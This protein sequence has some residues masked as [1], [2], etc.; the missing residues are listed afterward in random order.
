MQLVDEIIELLSASTPSLENALFKAQVL[1]HRLG[2]HD[3]KQWVDS[4]LKGYTDPNNVPPYR[5]LKIT[6]LGNVS[7]GAY[8]Y[9]SQ[10]LPLHHLEQDGLR[11]K[12]ETRQLTESIAVIERWAAG[13]N[14][15]QIVIAPELYP[16][17]GTGLG[18]GYQVERAWG[19]HSSGAMVQVVV[20]VRARLLDLALQVSD[21]IPRDPEASQIKEI[22]KEIAVGEIFRNA[23]FGDNATILV[24]TGNIQGITNS[25]VKNDFES[26]A[27][28][29]RQHNVPDSDIQ[30]LHQAIGQDA[31]A[32]ELGIKQIGPSV[33]KWIGSMVEKAGSA[34]WQVGIGAAGTILGAAIG[35]FYGI[36]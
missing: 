9:T 20:E 36:Q 8:R 24:G 5:V 32:H 4:E 16:G 18:N 27:A 22:S 7:N 26:L 1:A 34:T 21:R 11:E 10:P 25:I 12:L 23:V 6:L 28:A 17:L 33:R 15:L 30:A 29:L 31:N 14:A 2:E 3:L 19:V 35:A 13:D